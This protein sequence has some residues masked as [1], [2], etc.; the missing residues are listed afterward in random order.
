[1]FVF[2][3]KY[4]KW[5]WLPIEF[6]ISIVI[7]QGT[8]TATTSSTTGKSYWLHCTNNYRFVSF[9]LQQRLVSDYPCFFVNRWNGVLFDKYQHS[10]V[11]QQSLRLWAR[12]QKLI[13]QMVVGI[14]F[15]KVLLHHTPAYAHSF[16]PSP[17]L[18][19]QLCI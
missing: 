5:V 10:I 6:F 13:V 1:M 7:C 19:M 16:S 17:I 15:P 2:S 4:F 9:K 11:L 14:H 3:D 8:T 12:I 18:K